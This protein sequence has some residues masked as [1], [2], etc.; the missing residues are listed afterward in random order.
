MSQGK[1]SIASDSSPHSE[2]RASLILTI[3]AEAQADRSLVWRGY[4]EM[5]RSQRRY[6]DTLNAL[7]HLLIDLGWRDPSGKTS[8]AMNT[9]E[10]KHAVRSD[11][12]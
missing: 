10:E 8:I 4:L 7:G 12:N 9:R 3:W 5:T 2:Q 6:F 11:V 1:H